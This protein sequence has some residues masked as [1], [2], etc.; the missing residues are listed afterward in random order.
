MNLVRKLW[1]GAG[2]MVAS[3]MA[4]A[5]FRLDDPKGTSG[6]GSNDVNV[7]LSKGKDTAQNFADFVIIGATFFG[8]CLFIGGLYGMYK[9]GKD[10]RESP[11]GAIWA[12]IIGA[13]LTAPAVLLG[14][15]RNT[16]GV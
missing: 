1:M 12:V 3:G 9:A 7:L 5:E 8:L 4:S 2:L 16:F 10:E 15:T 6:A 11:K 14:L 13:A